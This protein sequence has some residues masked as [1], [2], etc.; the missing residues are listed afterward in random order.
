[1]RDARL[2]QWFSV[3]SVLSLMAKFDVVAYGDFPS[4]RRVMWCGEAIP[5]PTLIY[6]MQRLPHASFTNLY[7]PTETTI[8]SS[9]YTVPGC[10]SD[11]RAPIPIGRP[12]TGEELMILDERLQPVP[13]GET[14]ELYIRGVGVS[15][16][17]RDRGKRAALF[18]RVAEV[19]GTEVTPATRRAAIDGIH[20]FIGQR[21]ADQSRGT[22]S[23]AKPMFLSSLSELQES[24]VVA[25]ASEG[26]EGWT[27][28]LHV[29]APGVLFA[30][31]PVCASAWPPLSR[32][33]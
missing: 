3:P 27:M 16:H 11:E 30:H 15:P 29:P 28:L 21:H 19:R 24:A 18:S 22:A 12:C 4:L 17:G 20:Y 13:P 31:R 1:M 7:G 33:T 8:A 5:T 26:F 23:V 10:P 2:T 6:W 9:Y 32:G 25:I 14:G